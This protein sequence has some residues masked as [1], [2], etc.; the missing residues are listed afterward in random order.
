MVGPSTTVT[1][2]RGAASSMAGAGMVGRVSVGHGAVGVGRSARW[3][4]RRWPTDPRRILHWG[5]WT[6]AA[7]RRLQS[8]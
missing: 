5:C 8:T 1:V 4:N 2:R 7:P 6:A 3:Q